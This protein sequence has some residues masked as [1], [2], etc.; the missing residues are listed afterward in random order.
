MR[1]EVITTQQTSKKLKA[2]LLLST[3]TLLL[4]GYGMLQTVSA[5]P[6]LLYKASACL[7]IISFSCVITVKTLIW[8]NHE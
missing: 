4:G 2:Y 1:N 8:W 7:A 5:N 3:S 6:G